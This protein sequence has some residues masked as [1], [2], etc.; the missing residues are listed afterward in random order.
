MKKTVILIVVLFSFTNSFTQTVIV[1]EPK[2]PNYMRDA[3]NQIEKTNLEYAKLRNANA[4]FR[5]E[6]LDNE[7]KKNEDEEVMLNNEL[8]N[9]D[10]NFKNGKLEEAMIEI[11]KF[12]DN[13]PDRVRGYFRRGKTRF[14]LNNF[15]G[16]IADCN[17]CIMI[18]P[19][20]ASAYLLRGEAKEKLD[21]LK[22]A[23]KDYDTCISLSNNN[24]DDEY[25][26][27][28][29]GIRTAYFNRGLLKVKLGKNGCS[30]LKK[31]EE[32]GHDDAYEMVKKYCN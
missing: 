31:A 1:V 5:Q 21:D 32:L 2:A 16:T 8:S 23:L 17:K 28:N 27:N 18:I 19:K 6:Q 4:A 12:I 7:I 13:H 26:Y 29:V 22:E 20:Y 9:F 15:V 3:L 30:D 10:S 24:K 11:N 14:S 25:I